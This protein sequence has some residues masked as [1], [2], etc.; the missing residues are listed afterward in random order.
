MI[1]TS[2]AIS[3]DGRQLLFITHQKTLRLWDTQAAKELRRFN[4]HI[5]YV[6]DLAFLPG[7]DRFVTAGHDGHA[8]VWDVHAPDEEWN[9]SFSFE[10]KSP[11]QCLAIAP[12]GRHI[13]TGDAIGHVTVWDVDVRREVRRLPRQMDEE[14]DPETGS[15]VRTIDG[16][17]I[18]LPGAEGSSIGKLTFLP[19]SRRLVVYTEDDG[20]LMVFDVPTG[21]ELARYHLDDTHGPLTSMAVSPDGRHILFAE[22]RGVIRLWDWERG[23]VVAKFDGQHFRVVDSA[24]DKRPSGATS[25]AFTPDGKHAL[26]GGED[27][28]VR[29]WKL[30]E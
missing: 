29:L 17:I 13:A 9:W 6:K 27:G 11:V 12:N 28:T 18:D 8:I 3:P 20:R 14:F 24:G 21:R 2:R 7:A 22:G 23:K 10:H 30:P 16:E 5:G 4:G 15:Y 26:S 25:L 1:G 19:D